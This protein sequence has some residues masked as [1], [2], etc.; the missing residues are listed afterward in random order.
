MPVAAAGVMWLARQMRP[1]GNAQ[2]AALGVIG[3]CVLL[4][5]P[6][7][8]D[9]VNRGHEH[10]RTAARWFAQSTPP[11]ALLIGNRRLHRVALCADRAFAEWPW[12]QGSVPELAEFLTLHARPVTYVAVDTLLMTTPPRPATFMEDLQAELGRQLEPVFSVPAPPGEAPDGNQAV[13][14][15]AGATELAFRSVFLGPPCLSV[16]RQT[17]RSTEGIGCGGPTAEIAPA[18]RFSF[19]T[20]VV[21]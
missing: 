17:G 12:Y 18:R 21:R 3:L 2:A 14:V 13:L 15:P 1:V 16:G 7:L 11:D 9:P 19:E 8:F 6:W 5:S 20:Q 4:T 10:V